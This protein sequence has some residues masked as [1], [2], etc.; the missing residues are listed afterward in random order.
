MPQKPELI[1]LKVPFNTL[2]QGSL[3]LDVIVEGEDILKTNQ[4]A[5][6]VYEIKKIFSS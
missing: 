2:A 1:L 6:Q 4:V 3:I 5:D